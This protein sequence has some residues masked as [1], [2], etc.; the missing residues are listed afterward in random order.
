VWHACGRSKVV[1][2]ATR[3]DSFGSAMSA[4]LNLVEPKVTA[5]I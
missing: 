1:L 5:A 2:N 4:A 3:R